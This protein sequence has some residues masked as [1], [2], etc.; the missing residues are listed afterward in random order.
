MS[1]IRPWMAPV[2]AAGLVVSAC[3]GGGGGGGSGTPA[4][5]GDGGNLPTGDVTLQSATFVP[6]DL[7][8]DVGKTVVWVNALNIGHTIT[9][10]GHKAWNRVE[11]DQ[12]GETF[13][14]EFDEAGTFDYYCEIHGSP[15]AGMHGTIT[16][17]P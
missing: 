3:G 6:E 1:G 7:T 12:R 11:V 2:V 16:V 8:V 17:G 5:P 13:Q 10:D 9:P 14:A 4:G 15:G